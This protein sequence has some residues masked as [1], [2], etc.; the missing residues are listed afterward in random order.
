[1][2]ALDARSIGRANGKGIAHTVTFILAPFRKNGMTSSP[3]T[4]RTAWAV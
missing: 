2:V 4:K 3:W 1:L